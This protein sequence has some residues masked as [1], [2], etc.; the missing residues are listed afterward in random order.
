MIFRVII[1][2]LIIAVSLSIYPYLIN[3]LNIDKCLD[4][5]GKWNYQEQFCEF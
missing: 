4:R 1:M 2:M 3:F 5:G